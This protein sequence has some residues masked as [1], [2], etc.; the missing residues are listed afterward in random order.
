MAAAVVRARAAKRQV[1]AAKADLLVANNEL[2]IA[3]AQGKPGK[4]VVAREHTRSAEAAVSEATD[5]LEV[6]EGLL[7]INNMASPSELLKRLDRKSE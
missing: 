3:I 4:V 1:R 6:V 5:D 2:D 7:D